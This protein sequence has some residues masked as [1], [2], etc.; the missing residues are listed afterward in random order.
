MAS[1]HREIIG[2][3]L[4]GTGTYVGTPVGPFTAP[5]ENVSCDDVIG[6][7]GGL[8]PLTIDRYRRVGGYLNRKD[9]GDGTHFE[10]CPAG[11]TADWGFPTQPV[12]VSRILS[13]SGPLTPKV[14][15]PV[16]LFEFKDIPGMLRHAG[17][18]LHG[19]SRP[20]GLNPIKEAGA[21]NLAYQFGW[22]PLMDDIGKMLAVA[23]NVAKKQRELAQANSK[24]GIRRRITLYNTRTVLYGTATVWST[25]NI[26]VDSRYTTE[27]SAK[28][29]ATIRWTPR[30]L[31]P[32]PHQP[33]WRDGFD[34]A[35]GTSKGYIPIELWKAMPWSWAIDWFA[36]LSNFLQASHNLIYYKPSPICVMTTGKNVRT[37]EEVRG[38]FTTVTGGSVTSSTKRR[39]IMQ[40]TP[41]VTIRLPFMDNFKLSI[42][43]SFAALKF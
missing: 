17:N 2:P 32:F 18:L 5:S 20:S 11:Y 27:K 40:P 13:Q 41:N 31:A 36:D 10:N 33:S 12:T 6:D 15:L 38:T 25:Y 19:I 16:S 34:A 30:D 37:Y 21:A 1:R 3:L 4:S 24:K 28:S 42:L 43:G 39:V 14:Y 29:W 9:R 22:K 35:Y 23:N 26:F 7:Y 8:H